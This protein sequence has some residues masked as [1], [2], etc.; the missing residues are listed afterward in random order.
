VF[1]KLDCL[2]RSS[3]QGSGGSACP[4]EVA[5]GSGDDDDGEVEEEVGSFR[6]N[7]L[8]IGNNKV[9]RDHVLPGGRLGTV[10]R[11]GIVVD[12]E[13]VALILIVGKG[14]L[15]HGGAGEPHGVGTTESVLD[16]AVVSVSSDLNGVN[17]GV[18]LELVGLLNGPVLREVVRHGD[19]EDE[20]LARRHGHGLDVL[21]GV[22]VL[23]VVGIARGAEAGGGEVVVGDRSGPLEQVVGGVLEVVEVVGTE[24]E[25]LAVQCLDLRLVRGLPD[26][27]DV[28]RA[29]LSIHS[30]HG[31]ESCGEL[32]IKK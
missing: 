25:S 17:P 3:H 9:V 23:H 6:E 2:L 7:R 1:F 12:A 10:V 27:I 28:E 24:I 30:G 29:C 19:L 18:I 13:G 5:C 14:L 26:V 31:H 22:E 15:G 32:H 16:I 8:R 21:A 4:D 11:H 20:H